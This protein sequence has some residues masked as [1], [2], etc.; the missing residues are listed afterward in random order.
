MGTSAG[1]V[2]ACL[3]LASCT[4]V[5]IEDHSLQYNEASGSLGSRVMLLNVVRAAKGYPMQFSRV[6][7]YT[8]SSR[9]DGS[10][11]FSLPFILNT[12]GTP[13]PARLQANANPSAQFKTGVQSLQLIDLN[14][15]EVQRNPGIDV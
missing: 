10:L 5:E 11:S 12:F 3:L 2:L 7:N 15:A 1:V 4:K 6:S 14:T 9:M 13:S 8:G